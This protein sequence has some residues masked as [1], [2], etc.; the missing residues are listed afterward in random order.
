MVEIGAVAVYGRTPSYSCEELSISQLAE[1]VGARALV[2]KHTD[3]ILRLDARAL[4]S[5]G[6][7]V[8]DIQIDR[9]VRMPANKRNE[10]LSKALKT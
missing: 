4:L 6:P 5:E 9:A 7:I 1:G 8:L 2:I 10:E 3:E